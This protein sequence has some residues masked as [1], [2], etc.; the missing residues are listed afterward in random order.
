[1]LEVDVV[2]EPLGQLGVHEAGVPALHEAETG[3][4]PPLA[5]GIVGHRAVEATHALGS[6]PGRDLEGESAGRTLG[7][8]PFRGGRDRGE[9]EEQDGQGTK[10]VSHGL[11]IPPRA[12]VGV[13]G[14]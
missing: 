6:G 10:R 3:R 2:G 1:M 4:V 5:E 12:H 13:T 14:V 7:G 9:S 8:S 11:E